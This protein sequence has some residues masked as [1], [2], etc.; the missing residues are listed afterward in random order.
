MFICGNN[1]LKVAYKEQ[2][3]SGYIYVWERLR[4]WVFHCQLGYWWRFWRFE[5]IWFVSSCLS[6]NTTACCR[7]L[8]IINKYGSAAF[9][10]QRMRDLHCVLACFWLWPP[11]CLPPK[12]CVNFIKSLSKTVW[13]LNHKPCIHTV[14]WCSQNFVKTVSCG[15]HT[16]SGTLKVTHFIVFISNL[17]KSLQRQAITSAFSGSQRV[18]TCNSRSLCPNCC[19]SRLICKHKDCLTHTSYWR[20]KTLSIH[21][22]SAVTKT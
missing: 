2:H 12:K 21:V 9:S 8:L 11:T 10:C 15:A 22:H 6:A 19:L 5:V 17:G 16:C 14:C 7:Y 20:K 4:Q 1:G 18:K 3:H 13:S